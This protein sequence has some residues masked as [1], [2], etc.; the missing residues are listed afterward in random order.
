MKKLHEQLARKILARVSGCDPSDVER[1][2]MMRRDTERKG[3]WTIIT[4]VIP[5]HTIPLHSVH[6]EVRS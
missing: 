2:R 1:D 4:H 3:Y 5:S 6:I